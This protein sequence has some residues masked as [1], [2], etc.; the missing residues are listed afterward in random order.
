MRRTYGYYFIGSAIEFKKGRVILL[1]IFLI[2]CDIMF[3]SQTDHVIC[4]T[5]KIYY[6]YTPLHYFKWPYN[7][8]AS[9]KRYV[10]TNPLYRKYFD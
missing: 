6:T 7:N 8:K 5:I 1:L 10:E 2:L 4:K 3:S 9:D